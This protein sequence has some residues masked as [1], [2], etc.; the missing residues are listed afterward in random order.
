MRPLLTIIFLLRVGL[1]SGQDFSYPIVKST[2]QNI[3]DFIPIGW[4]LLDSAKGDLNNDKLNDFAI[5]L[6]HI[7]SVTFIKH[8]AS[9]AP[10]YN[11]TIITQPRILVIG[12]YSAKTN[13]YNLIEQNNSFILPHDNPIMDDPFLNISIANKVLQIDFRIWMSMG[14][15]EMS[16]NYYKFRYQNKQFQLIGADYNSANRGSGDTEDRSYNFL[17]KKVKIAIGNF[18]NDKQDV[19]WRTF[20]LKEVKTLSTFTQPFT[21]EIEKDFYL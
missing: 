19:K 18:S 14:S 9:F 10:E 5:V 13:R 12:F 11:D 2:G 17:T 7:D 20:N 21:W 8:E 6:E 16:T 1:V 15:W 3:S 4:T